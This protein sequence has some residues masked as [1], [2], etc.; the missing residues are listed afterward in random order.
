MLGQK[1]TNSAMSKR[2][3][4]ARR[5]KAVPDVAFEMLTL[6]FGGGNE[7]GL[8]IWR[9]SLKELLPGK[10]KTVLKRYKQIQDALSDSRSNTWRNWPK[11]DTKIKSTQLKSF[12]K[13][14]KQL[15]Y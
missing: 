9:N 1:D 5:A 13:F 4:G 11:V 14:Q 2:G 7:R 12:I 3:K 15:G 6:E 10:A 8:A